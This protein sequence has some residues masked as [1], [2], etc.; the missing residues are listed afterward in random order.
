[1]Q[2]KLAILMAAVLACCLFL[3]GCT[4][5]NETLDAQ[6]DRTLA[7]L[8]QDDREAFLALLYP[9]VESEADLEEGYRQIREIWIPTA[10]ED[11]ELVKYNVNASSQQKA[12]Q[13]IYRLP[14]TDEFGY[15][16]IDYLE[17]KEGR[18]L[19]G[20]HMGMI[21]EPEQESYGAG[22]WIYIVLYFA[23]VVFTIVDII[24]KKP[25][26]YGWYI[27]LALVYF[28]LRINSFSATIPLGSIV[29]WCIR[30]RLLREKEAAAMAPATPCE[31]VAP[32]AFE[33][34]RDDRN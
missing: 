15:L 12:Y 11:V 23:V 6:L 31:P 17:T 32:D 22:Q 34:K 33:A 16:E 4:V 26:K 14:R 2:K 5:K 19:V 28:R 18:G 1:M 20:L 8:N 25:R 30:K 9:G 27:L 21:E 7:A 13:G 10:R 24:R 29:Y 3:S